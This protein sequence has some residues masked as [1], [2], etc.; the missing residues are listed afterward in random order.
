MR[1]RASS[2]YYGLHYLRLWAGVGKPA[3]AGR[4]SRSVRHARSP[5]SGRAYRTIRGYR[6]WQH[7][8]AR[9]SLPTAH[10][11]GP[12]SPACLAV[13]AHGGVRA[14]RAASTHHLHIAC[15]CPPTGSCGL[16][17]TTLAPGGRMAYLHLPQP[18]GKT[19][20]GMPVKPGWPEGT[21]PGHHYSRQ[22][23]RASRARG[24]RRA[25]PGAVARIAG[26]LI[27]AF[28]TPS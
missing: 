4:R 18:P 11:P 19:P 28:R 8:P 24:D 10:F 21:R 25:R 7:W 15:I 16:A 20:D 5:L 27:R 3:Q 14:R 23:L 13:S 6:I 1:S 12:R 17:G 26:R 9:P 22:E 2:R